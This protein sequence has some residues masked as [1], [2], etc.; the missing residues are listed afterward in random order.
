[1][2]E[3]NMSLQQVLEQIKVVKPLAE[4]DISVGP[5][6]TYSGREGR[7]RNATDQYKA[8]K[9][10]YIDELRTSAVFI[11][12][13]GSLKEQFSETAQKEFGCFSADPE[14][15]YKELANRLPE[16]LYKNKTPASN[17]FDILGRHLEDK[18]QEMNIVGYPQLIM[19]QQYFKAIN[20]KEDFVSLIKQA[21]NEQVGSEMVGIHISRSLAESAIKAEHGSMLTPIVLT[22]DDEEFA[23]D[24]N[25]SLI[26]RLWSRSYLV[27]AGKGAKTIRSTAGAFTIKEVSKESVENVLTNISN[28]CKTR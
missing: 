17:L 3:N 22:T 27:V 11:L 10:Q 2:K 7:K 6:E 19:K 1:M 4:E 12:V 20:S 18:A 25:N 5:R 24:L 23:L 9:E 21:I 26:S 8:L 14:G 16:E 28:L 15:L 13:S